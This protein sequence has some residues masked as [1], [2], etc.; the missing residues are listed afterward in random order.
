[1]N[2]LFE[3]IIG[4]IFID[5]CVMVMMLYLECVFCIVVNLWYLDEW[6][7]DSLWMCMFCN[8]CKNVG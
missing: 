8:V 4:I 3:G 7:E 6:C 5:G 2:G 1:M